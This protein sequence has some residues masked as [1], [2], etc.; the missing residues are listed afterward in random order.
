M[1]ASEWKIDFPTLGYLWEAWV[2][3]HCTVPGGYDVGK[4]LVWSD[5]QFWV[6]AN[7]GRVKEKA[8]YNGK[9]I[10][11]DAF[12]YSRALVVAP[13][14]TGK[15]PFAATMTLLFAVGPVEFC[16]W[17]D[18][19]E[20]YRC[21]DHGCPCGFEFEYKAGEPMGVPHPQP[22][23]QLAAA[24]EDQ[25]ANTYDPLRSMVSSNENLQ[26]QMT[27]RQSFIRIKKDTGSK[28]NARI[29]VVSSSARSRLGN[30]ITFAVMDETGTWTKG[31]RL[32]S[33]ADTM[34]RS[35]A[36]MKGRSIETTNAWNSSENSVAQRT[37]ESR[38]GNTF[39]FYEK[40]PP[41]LSWTRKR[42][43]RKILEAV[44]EGSPW[45]SIDA[46]MREAEE[47]SETDPHMAARF[48]GNKITQGT[49]RYIPEE[50]WEECYAG[51]EV[52]E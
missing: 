3:A 47:L 19:T 12:H 16:G 7:F 45:V 13:Q 21:I 28:D 24:S 36:G 48:F 33:L 41:K 51:N 38:S 37:Y 14:K 8:T 5:W 23:I 30:P 11:V 40:P 18:G 34:R 44:Y 22:L 32:L 35:L 31:N 6:G 39:I 27:D 15:G 17:S 50:L 46:V 9:L 25:V 4:P 26:E 52:V 49:G 10:G 42:D 2:K 1:P 20:V 29:D 43:R